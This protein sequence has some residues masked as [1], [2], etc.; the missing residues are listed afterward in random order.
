MDLELGQV[1]RRYESLRTRSRTRE[2]KLL[3]SLAE[4][5]Q[6]SPVVVVRDAAALVLVDGFK[7]V[8][9]LGRLGHDLVQ[10]IEWSVGEV[11]ALMLERMLRSGD[12]DSAIEEGWFLRELTT[13]F[14]LGLEELSR[15]FDRS[16]SWV[17]RR[18][19]IVEELPERVQAHVREGAIGAHAAMKFLVPLARAN[20]EHVVRLGDAIAPLRLSNRQVGEL[21][22]T[23]QSSNAEARELLMRDPMLV[24]EARAEI[25]ADGAAP[26]EKLLD[27]L[28]I[29]AAVARRAHTRVV[30]GAM[31]GAGEEAREAVRLACGTAHGEV[32][33]LKRRSD[34]EAKYAGSDDAVGHPPAA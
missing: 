2:R 8:R 33:R 18:I 7:R 26:V 15:R 1:D 19:G 32:E 6:Q 30:R 31:D 16:K 5:G 25:A 12:A 22:A 23:Y 4:I 9:A 29:V 10:A 11:D 21:Y 17:S 13:R 27:D 28:H 3:A 20:E 24:L 34:R 14:G